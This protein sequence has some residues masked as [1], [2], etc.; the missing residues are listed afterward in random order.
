[1]KK[2]WKEG[3]KEWRKKQKRK[4]R[5]GKKKK[6]QTKEYEEWKGKGGMEERKEGRKDEFLNHSSNM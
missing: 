2:R 5:K 6:Q 3:G 1:M 4:K